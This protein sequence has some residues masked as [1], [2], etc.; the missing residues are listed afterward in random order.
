MWRV[1]SDVMGGLRHSRVCRAS[2]LLP[3]GEGLPSDDG[4]PCGPPSDCGRLAAAATVWLADD[5]LT[6][7]HRLVALEVAI[8]FDDLSHRQIRAVVV[9]AL[10]KF[11]VKCG[12]KVSR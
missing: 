10:S 4:A 11:G 7:R 5:C 1:S 2:M 8:T 9:T 3:P 12:C 6:M